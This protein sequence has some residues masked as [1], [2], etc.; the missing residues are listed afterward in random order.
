MISGSL[1]VI[2][3]VGLAIILAFVIPLLN[4]IEKLSNCI[5]LRWSCVAVILLIMVGVVINFEHLADS[6]RDIV[7]K[8]GIII[9]GIFLSLRTLEKVLF[10][11]WLKGF[12]LKGSLQKDSI[13]VEGELST[14]DPDTKKDCKD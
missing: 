14:P 2:V 12:N 1:A 4:S 7:L 10:Y 6:T 8:G 11:G 5:S 3:M 13:R 9:V